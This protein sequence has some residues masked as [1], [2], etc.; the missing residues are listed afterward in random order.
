MPHYTKMA[1]QLSTHDV[2]NCTLLNM[3]VKSIYQYMYHLSL[4]LKI[5]ALQ[6][7]HFITYSDLYEYMEILMCL[8]SSGVKRECAG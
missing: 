7:L 8:I 3:I 5:C 4:L 6:F 2:N 1:L